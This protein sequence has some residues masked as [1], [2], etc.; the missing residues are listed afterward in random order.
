MKTITSQQS[1][2][3]SPIRGWFAG[4]VAATIALFLHGLVTA[5]MEKNELSVK[6]LFMGLL[7][8]ITHF[9]FIAIFTAIPAIIFLWLAYKLRLEYL[10]LFASFGG[11]LG[12]LGIKIL[13]PFSRDRILWEFVVAGAIAGVAAWYFKKVPNLHNVQV[14]SR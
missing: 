7:L 6:L 5:S 2:S 3:P 13:D 1:L 14:S 8:S 11:A 4:C 10:I 9:V 12:W